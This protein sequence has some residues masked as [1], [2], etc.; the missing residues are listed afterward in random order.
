MH[1]LD[2]ASERSGYATG[3]GFPQSKLIVRQLD[4]AQQ[5][6]R[7][8][9]MFVY[10][11]YGQPQTALPITVEGSRETGIERL[12]GKIQN[13]ADLQVGWD[14]YEGQPA[15]TRSL[16]DAVRF[17]YLIARSLPIPR[18]MLSTDGEIS[19]YWESGT[20]YAEIDFPGDGT[21]Y[22]FCESV[23]SYFEEDGLQSRPDP[24]VPAQLSSFLRERFV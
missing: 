21:F 24:A 17:L 12:L 16:S 11:V 20:D 22:Y 19:L 8:S 23:D 10:A 3:G 15:K 7:P 1:L 4:C 6:A 5:Y 2:L 14:G 13:Y 9:T 18:A